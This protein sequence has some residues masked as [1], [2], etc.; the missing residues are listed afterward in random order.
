M[1]ILQITQEPPFD[2]GKVATGNAIRS[3]Q[4]GDALRTAGHDIHQVW[5]AGGNAADVRREKRAFHSRDQLLGIISREAP[6]V[7]LV[8]Y[9]ELL[10][11]LPFNCSQPVVLDFVAPRPLE[12]LYENPAGMATE[13]HRLRTNL[14]RCDLLLVGNSEQE[15][16]LALWLLEAG[17]D[18]RAGS[19]TRIVPLAGPPAP[20]NSSDPETSGWTVVAGG[21]NW[22]WREAEDYDKALD[23]VVRANSGQLR[24]VRFGG[25]YRWHEDSAKIG[26][27]GRP[28]AAYRDYS[29]FLS[30]SAHLGLELGEDNV[31]RR[32]SQSFRSLDF[33]RH[34]LPLIC[35][36]WLPLA[37]LIAR[38]RAGW[39]V[40][41]ANEIG[42]LLERIMADPDDWRE[43]RANALKLVT[44]PLDPAQAAQPL[45]DWLA[46]PAKAQRLPEYGKPDTTD[47]V[48]ARPPVGQ[49]LARRY[50]LARRVALSRW[51]SRSADE[52]SAIVLLSRGDLFPTD[53]G[54]AVKIVE[55]ARGLSRNGRE[56]LLVSDD[57]DRYWQVRDGEISERRL[58]GWLR[59]LARPLAWVK[60]D[61]YTR[62][63]PESNAFLYLPLSDGS[64]FW[65]TLWVAGH[66]HAAALQAEFPAYARPCIQVGEVLEIPVVMVEHNVEYERLR[67]QVPDLTDAQYQR[68]KDIEIS[69]CNRCDAVICVSDNDRQR[70]AED[71]VHPGLLHTVPHG[72]DLDAQDAH[73]A[74]NVRERF[75]I[76]ADAPL[77]AY[78]GTF[79][80][81]PNRDALQMLAE[82]ILPRLEQRGVL[83]HVVAIGRRP[84]K[85]PHPRIHC[86]GSVA[87]MAPWLKAADLA[88]IPLREGGGTR[89]KIIDCFAAGL[90]VVSTSKGIEGIPAIDGRDALVRDDWDDLVEAILEVLDDPETASRLAA[91][92]RAIAAGLD[93]RSIGE[94][95]LA[96]FAAASR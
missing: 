83:A 71:G 67:Q 23:E 55:T 50:R 40:R 1:R 6:D 78:H 27:N 79:A 4:L 47:P 44:G 90:P 63:I 62:D 92:G 91:A 59:L 5:L 21:V 10:A 58:P 36:E 75:E 86:P 73:P 89:M 65:R 22:P 94:R 93:W 54:A 87:S 68:L 24:L 57:R 81:P 16:L 8:A 84:P 77:L 38:H 3:R 42:P 37:G 96:I 9:W 72:I 56:V 32:H 29:A 33:L 31:E 26:E 53:H 80:Y 41:S 74:E 19:P 39:T 7:L 35:N 45:I 13:L 14:A 61:H 48:L 34:G 85:P 51:F 66:H 69:L 15:K 52:K 30:D 49:R 88:V 11:L 12:A 18:L 70:L 46:A 17:F 25:H 82:E 43:R 64:F 2:P 20:A 28:L 76:P 60:L 95:Y